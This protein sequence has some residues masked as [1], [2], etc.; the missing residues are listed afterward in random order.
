MTKTILRGIT[1]DGKSFGAGQEAELEKVL[2]KEQI[3]TLT[4]RGALSGY[5]LKQNENETAGQKTDQKET[6][7]QKG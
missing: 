4:A 7:N 5:E 1:V 2:S 3:K 6:K